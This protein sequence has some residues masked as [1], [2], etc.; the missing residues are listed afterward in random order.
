MGFLTTV[1]H[2]LS[3]PSRLLVLEAALAH[4]DVSVGELAELVG[5]AVSTTSA[6]VAALRAAGLV[7]TRRRGRRTMVQARHDRWRA[8][9]SA[10]A[11][12]AATRWSR[13]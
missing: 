3:A 13:T 2:A 12:C 5:Y 1:G 9:V 8:V 10:C 4:H 6:H 11:S 7:E